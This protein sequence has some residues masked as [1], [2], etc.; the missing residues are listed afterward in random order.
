MQNTKTDSTPK[1]ALIGAALVFVAAIAFS[2]KAIFVKLAYAY[3]VDAITLLA[4]RMLL[5]TPFFALMALW[6][7]QTQKT[8]MLNFK[9]WLS[10]IALGLSGMYLS[11]LLDFMGLE[12]ISAGLERT[13]LFLYPTFVVLISALLSRKAIGRQE[14]LALFL[15]YSGILLI[16]VNDI[17]FDRERNTLI[18]AGFILASSLTYASYLV[19]SGAVIHKIGAQRFTAYT[20]VVA[21]AACVTHFSATHSL[22]SLILPTPVYKLGMGMAI[23]STILPVILFNAGI[24][25]VGSNKASL[26]GSVGPVSTLL[27]AAVFLDEAMTLRQICG[28]GLVLAGVLSITVPQSAKNHS[29]ST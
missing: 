21:C 5:A 3:P 4:L 2:A 19:A 17:S 1:D 15:S 27:L 20:M 11:A 24:K 25:K 29:S 23:V 7:S 16:T 9:D 10:V 12:H 18:G 28:T 26:I 14:I 22:Y 6:V 13:I 8:S